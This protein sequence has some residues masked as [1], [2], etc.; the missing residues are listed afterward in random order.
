V[1]ALNELG[2]CFIEMEDFEQQSESGKTGG[3]QCTEIARKTFSALELDETECTGAIVMEVTPGKEWEDLE[4]LAVQFDAC[5][6][7]N[8]KNTEEV[9]FGNVTWVVAA[10]SGDCEFDTG[11]VP[12]CPLLFGDGQRDYTRPM[13]RADFMSAGVRPVCGTSATFNPSFPLSQRKRMVFR[14][15]VDG[16]LFQSGVRWI[17][18][19][20]YQL[21]G[22]NGCVLYA[23]GALGLSLRG[24]G[25]DSVAAAE[26]D[27]TVFT[28]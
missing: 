5:I 18:C 21:Y 23:R 11:E 27:D 22:C 9:C 24:G 2:N 6:A 4:E 8:A 10:V 26:A 28:Q 17:V 14:R 1:G 12:W 25:S 7:M 13:F 3:W 15:S 20:V 16:A 19:V